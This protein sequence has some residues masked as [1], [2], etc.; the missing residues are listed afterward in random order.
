MECLFEL[1]LNET[2]IEE[3]PLSV[4]LLSGLVY[5]KLERCKNLSSLPS[6]INGLKSLSTL[7]LSYCSRLVSLPSTIDGLKSLQFLVLSHCFELV[8]LPN[9]INGLESLYIL[10]LSDCSKL[11]SLPD[12]LG[13]IETL[14]IL[15]L[16]KTAIRQVSSLF[17]MKNLSELEFWGCK[18][19]PSKS[20][21]KKSSNPM[22]LI[23]PSSPSNLC[24]LTKLDLSD[25]N[26][27]EGAITSDLLGSFISLMVLDLSQNNFVSLPGSINRLSNLRVLGLNYCARLQILPKLPSDVRKL[28]VNSCISL[29]RL[30]NALRLCNSNLSE[31]SCHCFLKLNGGGEA[32]SIMKEHL[33]ANQS[34]RFSMVVPGSE[35]P[36]WFKHKSDGNLIKIEKP[37]DLNNNNSKYLVG[38]VMC[39]RFFDNNMSFANIGGRSGINVAVCDVFDNDPRKN[40]YVVEVDYEVGLRVPKSDHLWLLYFPDEKIK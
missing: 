30:S 37:P 27:G 13:Q 20:F 7:S 31:I 5:L 32:F 8:S 19:S 14:R 18:G 35:V 25:C 40:G 4:E 11:E 2:A 17:S 12:T 15:R 16:H 29:E 36:E 6:T 9:T 10:N 22:T 34:N 23:L 1:S 26:L 39:S 24:Y 21:F 38:Y 28:K 3:L 33:K